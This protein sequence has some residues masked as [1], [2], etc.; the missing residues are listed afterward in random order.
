MPTS[1]YP[2]P[3]DATQAELDAHES[4]STNVHGI[5]DTAN[6]ILEGD[7]R[8]TDQRVPTTHDIISKHNG[9][10][11]GTTNF[12][13]ADGTFAA[14]PGGGG[15]ALPDL[16]D[17]AD[18]TVPTTGGHVLRANGTAWV[19]SAIQ[20]SDLPSTIAR[21]SELH[22]QTHGITSADHTASGLTSGHVLRATGATT[23][24]FGAIADADLPA[25]IARDSEITSAI[26]THEAA[27][28]PHAGYQKESEKDAASGYAGL[29]AGTKLNLAQMQEVMGLT[30]LSNV[31]ITA[32]SNGQVL[33]FNGT[34]WVNDTD[35]TGGGGGLPAESSVVLG[36]NHANAT[37]TP[38]AVTGLAATL[39]A[40][41]WLAKYWLV[42]Q[43]AA[44]TTGIQM[45]LDHTGTTTRLAGT[46][47]QLTT[48]GAAATGVGD[49]ATT[50]TAQMVEGKGQRADNV[51]SGT[52]QGVDTANAD[53]FAV[54]EA[55]IVV[56]VSGTLNLMMNSEVGASAATIMSGSTLML[57]QVA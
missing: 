17:V 52:T 44:T 36:S 28:D 57:T 32:A 31:V 1:Q 47:Y 23:F 30:D 18:A 50:A 37:T 51:A 38:G 7:A 15:G 19:N 2:P 43:T 9:F 11:G 27:A 3:D 5:S 21:D 39:D 45:Y 35:A 22:A 4:D 26:T 10:P 54:Y 46:W 48:G 33:K 24:A 16:S 6:L 25:T 8:L 55:L 53:Q 41:T 20:D 56:T 14:P 40:G 12:L 34:N 49:Q 29:T 13:R 42:Y